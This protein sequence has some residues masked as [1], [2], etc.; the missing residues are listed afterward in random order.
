MVRKAVKRPSILAKTED[1]SPMVE[2]F[3]MRTEGDRL[4]MDCKALDSMR[5]DVVVTTEDIAK[6]MPVVKE[7]K[8]AIIAFAKQIPAAIRK[9][10]KAEKGAREDRS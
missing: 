2:V 8:A 10:K 3:S 1:G 5:M 6:G 7:S 9:Q 4:I